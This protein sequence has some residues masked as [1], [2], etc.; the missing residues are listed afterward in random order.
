MIPKGLSESVNRRTENTMTKRKGTKG[1][2]TIYKT[3]H[4][5]RKTEQHEGEL[6]RVNS[7]YS[8]SDTPGE[9][10]RMRRESGNGYDKSFVTQIFHNG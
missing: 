6:E 5:K 2:T 1:Q 7:S 4:R 10:T 3:S 8:T 9:R